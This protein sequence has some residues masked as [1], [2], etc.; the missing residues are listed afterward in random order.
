PTTQRIPFMAGVGGVPAFIES[1][2]QG[3]TPGQALLAATPGAT[4]MAGLASLGHP[5]AQ[6][7]APDQ[8]PGFLE[9]LQDIVR[10]PTLFDKIRGVVDRQYEPRDLRLDD[11]LTAAGDPRTTSYPGTLRIDKY[12][13]LNAEQRSVEARMA[14]YAE[15]NR[16]RILSDYEAANTEDGVI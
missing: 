12:R 4:M 9:R 16:E 8:G 5:R 7:R 15:A 3:V 14:H 6:D 11:F 13:G 10:G 2:Q 1:A